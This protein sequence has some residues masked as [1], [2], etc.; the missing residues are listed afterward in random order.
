MQ[1]DINKGDFKPASFI[2]ILK[3]S[4]MQKHALLLVTLLP[5]VSHLSFV[6]AQNVQ[7]ENFGDITSVSQPDQSKWQQL[8]TAYNFSPADLNRR[9]TYNHEPV[10]NS[11][12]SINLEGW[13]DEDVNA[14]LV[15]SAKKDISSLKVTISNLVSDNGKTIDNKQCD[16][17]FV[18][19]VIADNSRGICAKKDN[20]SYNTI[21]VPDIVDYR[22]GS[23]FAK[24]YTNRPVWLKIRIPRDAAPGIYKGKITASFNGSSQS[25]DV[26]LKVSNNTMPTA[27]NKKF[28]LELWQYPVAEADFYKVK[29]WSDEHFSL[30]RPA[31]QNLRSAGEDVITASFFW[32]AF[33]PSTRSADEMMIKPLK[34]QSGQWS[35]DFTNFDKWVN[36]M[37]DIGINKQITVFGMAPL[38]FK[39][40]Y[41]D[42]AQ[43][44]VESFQQGVNGAQYR[45]FWT[46]YLNAF[47]KHLQEKGWFDITTLAFSEKNPDVLKPLISFI[48]S[49]NKNWKISF[50]GKYFPEIQKDVYDYSLISNEQIP[51]NTIED[52]RQKGFITTFYT[53]CWERFPNTF[54][55]SDPVDATWL[56]WNA[57]NRNMDGYLR[58]AYDYWT[59]RNI[60]SDVRSNIASGD[61]FLIYPYGNSSVRFE[62]L[63]DGIEDYEKIMAKFGRNANTAATSSAIRINAPSGF[64][65]TLSQFDFKKVNS[66]ASRS[67]QI[68][69]ARALLE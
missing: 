65:S 60:I 59:M 66:N 7:Y 54:V 50:S 67:Q 52:R 18:Y 27:E 51:E 3:F 25:V 13:R 2:L 49:L 11:P 38:N 24:A 15:V 30:M 14:Q 31:M 43:N 20:T 17:G 19:Y 12:K 48:K 22:S 10:L 53:S 44:K 28:F 55:M 29:P 56:S 23:S 6:Q 1:T 5:F 9:V 61:R 4:T 68:R 42:E 26:L 40:Y 62:M 63:K 58:Y 16:A 32:D 47:Q 33:N 64:K 57:A 34:T 36:F 69:Q 35:Y 41:Y 46:S 39:Y 21:I 45:Q 37:M 8:K